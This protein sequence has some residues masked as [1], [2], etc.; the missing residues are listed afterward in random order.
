MKNYIEQR[1]HQ[2]DKH[3]ISNEIAILKS[4]YYEK[5]PFDDIIVDKDRMFSKVAGSVPSHFLEYID[6]I[7]V[8]HFDFLDERDLDAMYKHGSRY[9]SS[10]NKETEM[11][12][13]DDIIHEIAHAVE[14]NNLIDIYG[15]EQIESEF[16]GK[17]RRLFFLLKENGFKS[18]VEFY[19]FEKVEY[20]EQFDIFLYQEV[21]YPLM[22]NLTSGLFCSPYGATS[23]REYFA[24]CFE[25]YFFER[26]DN[27]VRKIS[28]QV[29]TKIRELLKNE[30]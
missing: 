25:H 6:T 20:E 29:Y 18:E 27:E 26:A 23:L 12:I 21:S 9:I 24:N 30:I 1:N 11:D 3:R 4:K 14:E 5:D 2:L 8:G 17:R 16:V 28:P 7:L 15:D 13:V 22:Q 19:D 10:K